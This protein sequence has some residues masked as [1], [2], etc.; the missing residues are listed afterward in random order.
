[1]ILSSDNGGYV[2]DNQGGCNSTSGTQ[3]SSSEDIGHGTACFNGEA[4]ASNWPLRGGK[5]SMWEGGIRVN[6]FASGGYLPAKVQG[7]KLEGIIHIA[8]WY[9]TLCGLAGVS[10]QDAEAEAS[11]LPPVDSFDMWPMLSGENKTSPRETILVTSEL[12]LHNQWKY[13]P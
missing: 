12:I 5:Y 10:P 1:M 4:G 6:A 11:G 13:V 3:G 7:T 8:D 2:K 9:G